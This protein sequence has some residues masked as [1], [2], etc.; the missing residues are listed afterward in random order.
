MARSSA[1]LLRK[2]EATRT[3]Y[4]PGR[5]SAKIALLRA[6]TRARLDSA[7]EVLRSREHLCFLRACPD[8]RAVLRQAARML[9][10]CAAISRAT[11][12][13]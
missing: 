13:R 3:G 10:G 11:G 7:H 12:I 4:G 1:S 8:N 2:L 5:A 9:R 6:L